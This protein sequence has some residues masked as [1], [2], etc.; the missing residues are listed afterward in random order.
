MVRPAPVTEPPD[1]HFDR[2]LL[3]TP[4]GLLACLLVV[5]GVVAWIATSIPSSLAAAL[6][7]AVVVASLSSLLAGNTF[8]M[9][10]IRQRRAYELRVLARGSSE[11]IEAWSRL[12]P[13]RT[14]DARWGLAVLGAGLG[15]LTFAGCLWFSAHLVDPVVAVTASLLG[16]VTCVLSALT[17][18]F[19]RPLD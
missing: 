18:T 15:V 11:R 8:R 16:L 13:P 9:R 17:G 6:G 10:D 12:V 3:R 1:R 4:V 19:I 7:A 14:L 5:G 2:A